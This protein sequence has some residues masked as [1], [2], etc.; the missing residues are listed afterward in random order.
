M[1]TTTAAT[2]RTQAA[3]Q[4]RQR[5]TRDKLERIDT[6][7]RAMRRE[8]T[9]ITYPAVAARAGVSRTFLYQNADARKLVATAIEVAGDRKR[10]AQAAHDANVEASWQQRALNAEHALKEA[11]AEIDTKRERIGLLLGQIRDLQAG[12]AKEPPNASRWR[13]PT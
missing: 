11:Y 5:S 2:P 13:T 8:R 3:N 1:T 9:T 10:R 12:T 4:A 7:L 6:T